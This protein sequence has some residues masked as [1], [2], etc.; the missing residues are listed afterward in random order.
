MYNIIECTVSYSKISGSLWQ[1]YR[2][3]SILTYAGVIDD[4]PGISHSLKFKWKVTGQTGNDGTKNVEIMVLLKYLRNFWRV[5]K[6][7][8]IN[9]EINLFLT[10]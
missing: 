1:Y 9:C 6:M 10:W 4:F 3:E 8:L 2:D 5:F 7:P